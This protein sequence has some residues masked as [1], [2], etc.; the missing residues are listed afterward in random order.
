MPTYEYQCKECSCQFELK[1]SFTEDGG[2]PCPKCHGEGRRLFRPVAIIFKGSGFYVTDSRGKNGNLDV[3]P[4]S[5]KDAKETA[6]KTSSELKPAD[7]EL[8]QKA[9]K[10][11]SV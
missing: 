4:E 2:A 7:K 10:E 3:E 8:A 9:S 6:P 1:R 5:K 11:G